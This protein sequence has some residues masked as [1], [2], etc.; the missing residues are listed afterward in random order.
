[1]PKKRT[2]RKGTLCHL[3]ACGGFPALLA[4]AGSLQT[5][6]AQTVQT[7]DSAAAAVLGCV[8]MGYGPENIPST[9]GANRVAVFLP[10]LNHST[11]QPLNHQ[12]LSSCCGAR[13]RANGIWPRNIPSA[14]HEGPIG[15]QCFC[16]YSTTH[17]P[18]H[19]TTQLQLRANLMRMHQFLSI[20]SCGQRPGGPSRPML[21]RRYGL[22]VPWRWAARGSSAG[23]ATS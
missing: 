14:R 8:P 15:R 9:R 17:P 4:A 11:T 1:M 21:P 19:P 7:P 13:L 5:R 20:S 18:N 12:P 23:A 10:L 6:C 2:K 16:R 3:S 22:P